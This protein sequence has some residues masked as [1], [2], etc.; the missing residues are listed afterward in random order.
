MKLAI[1]LLDE[2]TRLNEAL[3]EVGLLLVLDLEVLELAQ[4][5]LHPSRQGREK[6][7]IRL[8]HRCKCLGGLFG[9]F[10]GL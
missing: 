10:K 2:V 7:L 5:P 1:L 6:L 4:L 9:P 8:L 3:D